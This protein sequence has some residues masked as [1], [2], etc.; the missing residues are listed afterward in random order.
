MKELS[1]RIEVPF[2]N[3]KTL[4]NLNLID[5]ISFT[6]PSPL[7]LKDKIINS[8]GL[9]RVCCSWRLLQGL[10]EQLPGVWFS[11][12][13][14]PCFP[15]KR[16]LLKSWQAAF[17]GGGEC[18][19]TCF[20][21]PSAASARKL[22]GRGYSCHSQRPCKSSKHL[23]PLQGPGEPSW[24]EFSGEFIYLFPFYCLHKM[25]WKLKELII[26]LSIL[27]FSFSTW[28]NLALIA[29]L[30]IGFKWCT[31]VNYCPNGWEWMIEKVVAKQHAKE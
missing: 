18:S 2:R 20:W 7:I 11:L 5:L 9:C 8:S 10:R 27:F 23:V 4:N 19:E 14:L 31:A 13:S 3:I 30:F 17:G 26:S 28:L 25:A 29:H 24:K 16:S 6:Q 21:P 1:N 12:P 15:P 22:K